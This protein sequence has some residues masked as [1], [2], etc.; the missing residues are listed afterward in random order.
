MSQR[1]L[2][3][4]MNGVSGR[5]GVNQHLIRSVAAIRAQ[6]GV[7]MSDGSRVM[8]DP[9]LVSRTGEKV[10][11][12][13]EQHGGLRWTTD[14]DA[15]I[16]SPRNHIFFD[17]ATTQMR[18]TLLEKAIHAGKH[19]YCEKPIATNLAEA[20]KIC[21]LAKE[22]GIKNGTVQDKLFLPGLQKIK[23]LRDFG[24][25]RPHLRGARRVRLLGV[26]RR[27][28]PAGAA[29]VLELSR[30]GRRRHRARHGLPLALRARQPVR[31][32]E[33]GVVHRRHPHPRARRRGRQDLPRDRR[34]C[35]LCLLPARGRHHRPYQHE[36]GGARLPRRPR[37]LPGRRHAGL[38]G[39]RPDRLH[40]PAAHRHAAAGLEPR[41]ETDHRLLRQLAEDAGQHRLRERLQGRMGDVHPPRRRGCAVQ[42]L[43]GRGRQGRAARRVRPPELEGTA[44][45]RRPGAAR[46]ERR[47]HVDHRAPAR[48]RRAS[49]PLHPVRR[50]ALPRSH[51]ATAEPGRAGGSPRRGRSARRHRSLAAGRPRLGAH[52]RLSRISLGPRPRRRRGDGHRPARHGARLAD[53]AGAD[54]ALG[55][56]LARPRG[57]RGLLGRRH[58]PSRPGRDLHGRRRD[59]RL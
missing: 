34:R 43:A 27:L 48:R 47:P 50:R 55:R 39:R 30:R 41:P 25:L 4:I 8:L 44:L 26:R 35:G 46:S 38:G 7:L 12:L 23:L 20:L 21:R 52:H 58:R 13:A 6:G 14:L 28:G 33:V 5:M 31:Q 57:R 53:G 3:L 16:A 49:R 51:H 37:D 32:R 36:L 59:P 15:E 1:T 11:A 29:A 2:G 18:P 54:Q 24:L 19:I 22:K 45:G 56:R 40:D 17:T 10:K 42:A 9:V